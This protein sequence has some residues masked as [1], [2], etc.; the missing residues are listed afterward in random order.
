MPSS[1]TPHRNLALRLRA[2][3]EGQKFMKYIIT[4]NERKEQYRKR[5]ARFWCR[6][7]T[8]NG[9]GTVQEYTRNRADMFYDGC[10]CAD[11]RHRGVQSMD[12]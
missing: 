2:K 1:E 7:E 12:I 8:S 5:Y 10:R 11:P 9:A 3:L 6:G 4:Y